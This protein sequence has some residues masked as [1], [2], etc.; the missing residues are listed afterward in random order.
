MSKTTK[1]LL[2][3]MPDMEYIKALKARDERVDE[4][5][6]GRVEVSAAML[7]SDVFQQAVLRCLNFRRIAVMQSWRQM[8]AEIDIFADEGRV[9]MPVPSYDTLRRHVRNAKANWS[10]AVRGAP[11]IIENGSSTGCTPLLLDDFRPPNR[12]P[13]SK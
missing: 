6:S 7:V 12:T 2:L 1:P 4:N 9:S 13:A 8:V 3:P 10:S 5:D 11:S